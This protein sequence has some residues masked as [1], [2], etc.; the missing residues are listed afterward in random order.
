MQI[1]T[2]EFSFHERA[3]DAE[4][5]TDPERLTGPGRFETIRKKA[6]GKLFQGGERPAGR[7]AGTAASYQTR[8]GDL[9]VVTPRDGNLVVE[10]R[11]RTE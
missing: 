3:N 6:D 4:L 8:D 2:I 11:P 5:I 1:E 9:F 7:A 10:Y